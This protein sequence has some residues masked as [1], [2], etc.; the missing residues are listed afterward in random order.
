MTDENCSGTKRRI[1][2]CLRQRTTSTNTHL[3][4]LFQTRVKD[5]CSKFQ[6]ESSN[7][8]DE[9]TTHLITDEEQGD[10]L[11]CPLSKKVIQSVAR[12][13]YVVTY[14]WIDACLKANR[15]LNEK[16]FE[17]QG[18]LTLSSDH[19]GSSLALLIAGVDSL[20][21]RYA[22]KSAEY[23]TGSFAEESP[24]GELLDHA[25]MQRLPRNDEQ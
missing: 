16:P 21:F 6:I 5:F 17:I 3:G 11:V 20:S 22:A 25:E 2:L 8:V 19:N 10:T 9:S 12:H 14:R 13:M 23:P 4:T 7:A 18:D 1:P 24:S 15:I